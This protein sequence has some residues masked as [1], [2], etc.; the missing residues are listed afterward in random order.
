[1]SDS[2]LRE[3]GGDA[4]LIGHTGFVGSNLLA[5]RPFRDRFNSS[6]IREMAGRAYDLVVCAGV[7]AVKWKANRE[8]ERDWAGIR[9][10]L[11]VLATVR[12]GRFVLI[13]TVDVY[14]D[15]RGVTES[16][17]VHG[18]AN[19]PYGTHRLRVEDFVRERFPR[20]HILRLPGL[21]GRGL[22][23]NVLFDLLHRNGLE[24]VQPASS[25]QYY[26]LDR[27]WGDI[28]RVL[29]LGLPLVNLATEP[30]R[31]A[32]IL[33][34]HFPSL[35]VGSKAGAEVHYDMRSELARHWGR[36]GPYLYGRE[37]VMRDL[38]AFIRAYPG[39][40]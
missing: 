24:T 25:Y 14:P 20:H 37:D 23:K 29:E 4:A 13:S 18:R 36:P 6:N 40:P 32:E 16:S 35:P 33:A 3:P 38:G 11:D 27:L 17:P 1:M 30:V 22:K 15:P 9:P 10:L 2:G 39:A 21:F 7:S 26:N 19:H 34:A 31:T 5:Q 8:P 28:L 12:A